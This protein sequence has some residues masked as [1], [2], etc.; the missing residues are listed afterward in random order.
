MGKLISSAL[1]LLGAVIALLLLA[2]LSLFLAYKIPQ[3]DGQTAAAWFQAVGSV[4]AILFAVLIAKYQAHALKSETERAQRLV[5]A[6]RRNGI[7]AVA[8]AA[9]SRA[10]V[11]GEALSSDAPRM[12][13]Y[14]AYDRSIIDGMVAALS[15]APVYEL[16]DPVAVTALI[17]MRDQ[18]IFL[19][20]SVD[21]FIAGPWKHPDIAPTL[22]KGCAD[23]DPKFRKAYQ[24]M[25]DSSQKQFAKNALDRVA[26]IQC[27]FSELSTS[28]SSQA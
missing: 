5:E 14:S 1:A 26:S 3:S 24:D 25:A 20:E 7:L 11:I 17:K 10:T 27:A 22:I 9:N 6:G 16:G 28:L 8:A 4:A 15:A 2:T 13:L 12:Q 19:G 18:F 23:P 21:T